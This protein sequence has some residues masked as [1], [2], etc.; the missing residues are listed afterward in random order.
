MFSALNHLC[1]LKEDLLGGGGINKYFLCREVQE[2]FLAI[3]FCILLNFFSRKYHEFRKFEICVFSHEYLREGRCKCRILVGVQNHWSGVEDK[4]PPVLRWGFNCP[5]SPGSAPPL[6]GV[7]ENIF[8]YKIS[9][10]NILV[11]KYG[12]VTLFG[13]SHWWW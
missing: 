8:I 5:E 4:E 12:N 13:S 6:E 1:A 9:D 3:N 7:I 2:N 10:W 11:T